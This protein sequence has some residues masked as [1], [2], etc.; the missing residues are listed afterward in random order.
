MNP[1]NKQI[2][3]VA[4]CDPGATQQQITE[5]LNSQN[6]FL[7]VDILTSKEMLARQLRASEPDIILVDSQL[8][9]EST[10]DII[11]DLALQFPSSSVVAILPTNDPLIAQQ[12]MLAGARAFLITP[13]SQINLV[14]TLRRVSELEG[15]RQQTKTYIPTVVSEATRPLRSITV[16]SPRG[17]TGVTSIA[18]NTAIALAEETGKKVLLFE[19]KV[20]FGHLEVMLN[21]KV[22]NTLADLIPHATNMDEGLVRDV[23]SPHPSGIHVLMAPSNVQIA[24]GIRAEDIYN[25]YIG[26]SRLYDYIVVDAGGPLTDISVTLM[27]AADRILLVTTPDLASLHDTSRFLQLSR[28]LAYPMDKI[29]MIL[30][31]AGVEGGVKLRDIESVLHNQIYHQ[32]PNDPANVLRSINRGIPFLVY[33]PRSSASK[34]IQQLARN[35][36]A[37]TL[38]DMGHESIPMQG[39]KAGRDMLLASSHLG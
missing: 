30:N 6:E 31:K 23:V 18:T 15:R 25:V 2:R 20:F 34:S 19:G 27:D 36:T 17:G 10:M 5:A 13:F 4:L 37:I 1:A 16:Y 32:I 14:S 11:D 21:M 24:Q 38:K 26:V 28:S 9:S 39:E 3:V 35:I 8:E 7:L 22:Q 29:L 33:Y 12:V